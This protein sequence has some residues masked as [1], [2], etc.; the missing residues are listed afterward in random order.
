[1]VVN[2]ALCLHKQEEYAT[3][4]NATQHQGGTHPIDIQLQVNMDI[5]T[6]TLIVMHATVMDIFYKLLDKQRK[7]INIVVIIFMMMQNGDVIE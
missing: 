7:A 2:P 6:G 1:M 4:V 3:K 5:Y